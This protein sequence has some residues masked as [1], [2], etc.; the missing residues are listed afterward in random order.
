[1]N[2][3]HGRILIVGAGVNG[4]TCAYALQERGYAV[5][6]I[7]ETFASATTS[8][9][10]GALWELPPAVCGYS[11]ELTPDDIRRDQDLSIVSYYQFMKLARRKQ[12][13]VFIRPVNFYYETDIEASM[14]EKKK[15]QIAEENLLHFRRDPLIINENG[16]NN[17]TYTD[18]YS[19]HAPII[20]TDIYLDW[21]LKNVSSHERTNIVVRKLD[22]SISDLADDLLQEH[23]ADLI[24]NCSGLGA[25]QLA[26]DSTV[27]GA[28]GGLVYIDNSGKYSKQ[29]TQAHCT[30]LSE[31]GMDQGHFIFILPRG[32]NLL[33]LGGVA[34]I[35]QYNVDV[36][37]KN[38]PPY[39]EI[40]ERCIDFL[41]QLVNLKI[42]D[43]K[44]LRVGIRPFRQRGL[45]LERDSKARVIH[46]YGHGGAGVLLSWGCAQEVC[47]LLGAL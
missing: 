42:I 37:P 31:M 3:S 28:R 33:V 45:R 5:T 14:I 2:Y 15:L 10:A 7:A 36:S 25:M 46:N 27:Y 44:P 8:S 20:D 47:N 11:H 19:Y 34:E 6:L 40:I 17:A 29:I 43:Q 22:G 32:E 21:L 39:S 30:S 9:V 4:L 12:T 24:I 16:I 38:Y 18:A 35:G 26:G 41:P 1:M 13:G 23:T